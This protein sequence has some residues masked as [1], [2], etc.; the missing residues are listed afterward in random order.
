M[1]A[2]T[3]VAS[4]AKNHTT[5]GHGVIGL[6]AAGSRLLACT[7][8]LQQLVVP[9]GHQLHIDTLR[10][11]QAVMPGRRLEAMCTLT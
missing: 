2:E 11:V 4:N 7:K 1:T 3:E 8:D 5:Q 6:W 9:G 10:H